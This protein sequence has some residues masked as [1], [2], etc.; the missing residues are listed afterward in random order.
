MKKFP[1]VLV[2]CAMSFDGYIDDASSERL[3]LS[4]WEDFDG[5]D[6]ERSL[7]DAILIGANTLRKDNPRILV[8]S[9]ERRQ[10]RVKKGLPENPLKVTITASGELSE[11]LNFFTQGN[12]KKLVYCSQPA[13]QKL[14]TKLGAAAE[15]VTAQGATLDP[16][17][18]LANLSQRGVRRLMIEGGTKILTTFLSKG[19]VDELQVS[20]APFFVG[21]ASAP[22]FVHPATFPNDNQH[23]MVLE[24]VDKIGD[25]ALLVYK[26]KETL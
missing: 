3:M 7:C 20:I 1:Y 17:M 15:V 24:K 8:K 5:V 21:E 4:N 18:V 14:A 6:A 13:F 10:E 9:E 22:R 2:K 19:L 26:P 12:A 25:M 11:H 23:R 16:E